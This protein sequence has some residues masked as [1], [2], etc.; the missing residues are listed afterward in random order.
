MLSLLQ[1]PLLQAI[2]LGDMEEV[3]ALLLEQE[4]INWQDKEQRSLLHAAAY[5]FILFILLLARGFNSLKM[6]TTSI[7]QGKHC[8]C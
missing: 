7:F 1:P 8:Y 5:R 4:D 3:F 6:L 2:F